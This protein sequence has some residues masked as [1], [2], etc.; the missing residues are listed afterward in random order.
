LSRGPNAPLIVAPAWATIGEENTPCA[1]AA[2]ALA[3]S[4]AAAIKIRIRIEL[5]PLPRALVVS[6]RENGRRLQIDT[7][8]Q[9]TG[10]TN[11]AACLAR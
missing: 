3:A 5:L 10:F 2:P 6:R 1:C 7:A 9:A 11:A 8:L 4:A